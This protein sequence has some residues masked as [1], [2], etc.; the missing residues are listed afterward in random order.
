MRHK[1]SHRPFPCTSS[2]S[3]QKFCNQMT[4]ETL[5]VT[6]LMQKTARCSG[7]SDMHNLLSCSSHLTAF[8]QHSH[9]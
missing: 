7:F 3:S 1:A 8:A 4:F 2:T 9:V 6:M 5:K